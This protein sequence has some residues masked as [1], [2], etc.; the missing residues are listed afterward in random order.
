MIETTHERHCAY[1]A[2]DLPAPCT[3]IAGR[4]AANPYIGQGELEAAWVAGYRGEQATAPAS[5]G[6]IHAFEAGR[7]KE[8]ADRAADMAGSGG[9]H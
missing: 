6:W 7:A 1:V 5:A 4:L 2:N 9:L 8:E 3:C